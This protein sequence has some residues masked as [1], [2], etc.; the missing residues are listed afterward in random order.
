[1]VGIVSKYSPSLISLLTK[2]KTTQVLRRVIQVQISLVILA[3]FS[4]KTI[5]ILEH[6]INIPL[7][8]S[9]Q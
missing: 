3:S 5:R 6:W 2:T 9:R 8:F 1:M 4:L 7:Y